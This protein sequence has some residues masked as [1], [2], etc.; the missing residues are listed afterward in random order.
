MRAE[1]FCLAL[2]VSVDEKSLSLHL[3]RWILDIRRRVLEKHGRSPVPGSV[4]LLAPYYKE[5]MD[6]IHADM[7]RISR[8]V[9]P[10][11]MPEEALGS[12]DMAKASRCSLDLLRK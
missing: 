2:F 7:R 9:V 8:Y 1:V 5:G 3:D 4:T 12:A 11:P 6:E 10:D